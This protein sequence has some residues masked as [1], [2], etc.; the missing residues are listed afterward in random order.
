MKRHP[1]TSSCDWIAYFYEN[2]QTA[3]RRAKPSALV[4]MPDAIRTAIANSLPA[5]QLGETSEGRHLRA[6]ARQ[7]A[8]A[9]DDPAFLSAVEL[10]I[11]EEQ[12]H[13]ASLGEWLDL[14]GIPRKKRDLGDSLFRICRYAIPNYAVWASVVVMVEFM[15]EIYYAAV[16]RLTMCPR[17]KAECK[18]ILQDEVK[19]IQF[20]CEHLA[21]TRRKLPWWVRSLVEGGELVFYTVVCSAVW[22]AHGQLL[23]AA[24]IPRRQFLVVS[25]EKFRFTHHLMDP[26]RYEFGVQKNSQAGRRR[27]R[28]LSKI[29]A[30]WLG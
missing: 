4:E 22:L 27:S 1:F 20:Q 2:A 25:A 17:L 13:G 8:E 26:R 18:R 14:A 12:R 10:F 11:R 23:T 30:N 29:A 28:R 21:M 7:Y 16:R 5:W 6:A 19:H 3:A 24:G 15:A 9:N